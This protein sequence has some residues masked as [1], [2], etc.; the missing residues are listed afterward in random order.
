MTKIAKF[1]NSK[2]YCMLPDPILTV[3]SYG[4]YRCI[5]VSPLTLMN[6]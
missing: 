4:T 2:I 1:E 5:Y 3:W 6:H